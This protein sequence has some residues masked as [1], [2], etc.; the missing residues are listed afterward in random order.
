[1]NEYIDDYSF[2]IK[3]NHCCKEFP[4]TIKYENSP[5][6]K[7]KLFMDKSPIEAIVMTIEWLTMKGYK[8]NKI[9]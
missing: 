9:E 4:W 6:F 1:M 2:S 8:L 5:L 3:Y 7:D